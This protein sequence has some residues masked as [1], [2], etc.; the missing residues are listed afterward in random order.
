MAFFNGDDDYFSSLDV[1]ERIA[2]LEAE[3]TDESDGMLD[4][5][6]ADPEEAEEYWALIELQ[7]EARGYIADWEYGETFI[8]DDYFKDYA[9]EL[10]SDIGAIG[11]QLEWPCNCIDWDAAA[12]ELQQDYT[13]FEFRGTTYWAR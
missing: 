13:S 12:E 5:G 7:E 1:I 2:E 11:D 9:Q 10:A 3:Y 6:E 8:S 4:L